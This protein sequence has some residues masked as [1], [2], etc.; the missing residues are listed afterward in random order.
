MLFDLRGPGRRN[1]VRVVYIGLAILIGGGL[2]L[3]GVGGGLGGTGLLTA[4]SNNAAS[5]NTAFAQEVKKYRKQTQKEP[6]NVSAWENYTRALLHEASSE[7]LRQ[8]EGNTVSL[9]KKGTEVY[10]EASQAWESYLQVEPHNPN[11]E[12][13]KLMTRIYSEE[14]LNKPTKAVEALQIVVAA[15]PHSA[16]YW[17]ELA[18]FAYKAKNPRIG[19]LASTKAVEL[20]PPAQRATV[21]RSLEAERKAI[22][23]PTQSTTTTG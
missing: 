23:H 22:E 10:G 17:G 7:S 21:K 16:A 2:V 15:E 12:L 8:T 20:A 9:T 5:G 14:G 6:Q 1:L 18:L 11:A 3:F 13:A 4:A 19:D